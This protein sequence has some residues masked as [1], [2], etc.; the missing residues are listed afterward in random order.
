[1]SQSRAIRQMSV[2]AGIVLSVPNIDRL[3]VT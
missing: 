2:I 1:M 3:H